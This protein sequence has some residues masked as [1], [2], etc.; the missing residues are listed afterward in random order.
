MDSVKCP[1]CQGKR[2]RMP[3]CATCS[4]RGS[5]DHIPFHEEPWGEVLP[6]LF[7]GGHAT[8]YG[9]VVVDDEFDLV[10]SLFS[11]PGHGPSEGVEHIAY[12]V[13][14]SRLEE[15]E[16]DHMIELGQVVAEAVEGGK[17]VLVRCHAGLNRSS[18]VAGMAMIEMGFP[19]SDA[20]QRIRAARGP[21][22]LC[23]SAFVD[24]LADREI[25]ILGQA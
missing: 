5:V 3:N 11:R 21:F 6:S 1:A 13:P 12:R 8:Q 23:N 22:A 18:L 15:R 10:V 19:A 4:G 14:D 25:E 16:R 7:V 9:S 2:K 24:Y 20:I 17:R